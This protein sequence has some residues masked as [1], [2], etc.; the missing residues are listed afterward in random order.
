M[1][2]EA[3]VDDRSPDAVAKVVDDLLARPQYGE[4][5]ARH[6]LD[7]VRYAETNGYE[8]DGAKPNAWRYRDYVIDAFNRDKPYDRFVIEQ[9]AGDEME[10]SDA[11]AQIATTFLAAGDLGRRAGRAEGR[12]LRPARRRAGHGGDRVPGHHASVCPLPRPQVRAVLAGRLLSHARR[13]RAAQASA[14]RP[15]RDWTARSEPRS[16]WPL[17][18]AAIAGR[19]PS[20]PRCGSGSRALVRPEID[21][22]L[23]PSGNANDGQ[24]SEQAA[25]AAARCRQGVSDRAIE[26]YARSARVGRG[27]CRAAGGRGARDRAGRG[28]GRAQ[29][30]WTIGSPR[31]T[32]PGPLP[33]RTPTSGLKRGRSPR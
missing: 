5:W 1:R 20:S 17:T 16:S 6:W 3:F 21:R 11:A 2:S 19:T 29:A 27:I 7:L 25:L 23:A 4:R 32:R 14:R 12:P 8:R 28:E 30:A 22:L 10:G 18:T 13:L 15:R 26:A 24:V 33:R 9:L 31:S